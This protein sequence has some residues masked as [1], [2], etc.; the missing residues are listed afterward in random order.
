MCDLILC[1]AIIKQEE[2]IDKVIHSVDKH[3]FKQKFILF[4][5]PPPSRMKTSYN[6]YKKYKDHIKKHYPDFQVIEYTENLYYKNMLEKFIK[7]NYSVVSQN[8]LIIQD[9]V[10][11]DEFD[12]ETTLEIKRDLDE[13]RILYFR[14]NR[15]RCAHWF[16]VIDESNPNLIKTHGWSER[17]YLI[18]KEDLIDILNNLPLKG[19]KGGKFIEFYYQNMM[20]RKTWATITE[21][22]QLEYWKRW[23]CY[24]HKTIHHKHLVAKR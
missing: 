15:K 18:T 2:Y 17:V 12:L 20:S 5:G 7:E 8:L 10:V 13:C 16:N 19:G 21:E 22:E 4:D 9:D 23:G 3:K 24:E 11:L 6:K 1:G 14:E